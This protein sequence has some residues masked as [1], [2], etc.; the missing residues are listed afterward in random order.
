MIDYHCK[1]RESTVKCRTNDVKAKLSL[2]RAV[3]AHRVVGRRGSQ[4]AVRLSALRAGHPL[5]TGRFLVFISVR[6]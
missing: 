1:E 4:M 5:L 6:D 3:E 2:Q